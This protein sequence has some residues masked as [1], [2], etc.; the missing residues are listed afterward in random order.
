MDKNRALQFINGTFEKFAKFAKQGES[1]EGGKI[2]LESGNL[3]QKEYC[4]Y[5]LK[6]NNL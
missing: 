4:G 2:Y 5:F 3:N 1:F 6:K